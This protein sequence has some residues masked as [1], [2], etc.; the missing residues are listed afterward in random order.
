[1]LPIL[2]L[3]V[4]GLVQVGLILRDQ[5]ALVEAARAGAREAAVTDDEG[6]VRA[7]VEGAATVLE[8]GRIQ[9]SIERSGAQGAPVTVRLSYPDRPAI[10]AVQWLFPETVQLTAG[11]VMRQEFG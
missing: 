8:A 10:T 3:V 5:L 2:L 7:A 9:I 1:M 4:L 6:K 11:A